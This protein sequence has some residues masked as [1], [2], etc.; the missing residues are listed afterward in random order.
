MKTTLILRAQS[1]RLIAD[2]RQALARRGNNATG[3]LSESLED[4]GG[5]SEINIVANRYGQSL[6]FGRQPTVNDGNGELLER[7]KAWIEVKGLSDT[8]N[9]YAV[10]KKIHKEGTKRWQKI[11]DGQDPNKDAWISDVVTEERIAEIQSAVSADILAEYNF[12]VQTVI[13]I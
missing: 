6:Q 11:K 12:Q 1:A 2:F 13:K 3:K 4:V 10:T 7:I 5:V 9:P 8:L